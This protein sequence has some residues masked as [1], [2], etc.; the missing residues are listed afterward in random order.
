MERMLDKTQ[1]GR[2]ALVAEWCQNFELG[3]IAKMISLPVK[4]EFLV[5][6]A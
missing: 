6:M 1:E 4:G 5:M 2:S 3:Y